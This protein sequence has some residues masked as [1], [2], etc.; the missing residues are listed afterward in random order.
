MFPEIILFWLQIPMTGIWILVF[1]I[2]FYFM[3]KRYAKEFQLPFQRFSENFPMYMIII[4][5]ISS[6]T[7]YFLDSRRIFPLS[8]DQVLEY[9]SPVGYE[10]HLI[11]IVIWFIFCGIHFLSEQADK[12]IH[13]KRIDTRFLALSVSIIPLGIFLLLGDNFIWVETNARYGISALTLESALSTYGGIVPLWIFISLLGVFLYLWTKLWRLYQP[14][15]RW[16]GLRW[17]ATFLLILCII[18]LFQIY[19]RHAVMSLLWTTWDVK[20]YILIMS[21]WRFV[22]LALDVYNHFSY[23]KK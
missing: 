5:I 10:F 1:L 2:T 9:I 18:I 23:L 16:Y 12:H 17:L 13:L 7:R 14:Q 21:S 20:N 15:V 22:W 6:Y 19:P 3:T 11:W 8:R 4:Y